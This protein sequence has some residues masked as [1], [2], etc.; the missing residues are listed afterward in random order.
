MKMD[1]LSKVELE[2]FHKEMAK[3][4]EEEDKEIYSNIGKFLDEEW[5]WYLR[6][7]PEEFIHEI[8]NVNDENKNIKNEIK[9]K[10]D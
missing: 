5:D 3:I 10:G 9:S 4:Q 6:T 8:E 1:K 7:H 2:Q